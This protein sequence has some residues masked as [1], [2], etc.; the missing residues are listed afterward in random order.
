MTLA[1]EEL[2]S[3]FGDMRNI[4][5]AA[6]LMQTCLT[7]LSAEVAKKLLTEDEAISIEERLGELKDHTNVLRR[8]YL[9]VSSTPP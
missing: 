1:L 3:R 7:D 4:E 5:K 9:P 8:L 6:I 2:F